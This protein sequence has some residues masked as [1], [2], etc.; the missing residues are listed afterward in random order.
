MLTAVIEDALRK[1]LRQPGPGER[2]PVRLPT[3]RG[4][5]PQ[6]GVDLDDGVALLDVMEGRD[7]PT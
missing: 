4:N 3:V 2:G 1:S 6:P 7:P 5:G